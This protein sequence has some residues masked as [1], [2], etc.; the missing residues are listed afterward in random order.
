[1]TE[2]SADRGGRKK[3]YYRHLV[4]R[5]ML[6]NILQKTGQASITKSYITQ[7]TNSA[8]TEKPY[9]SNIRLQSNLIILSQAHLFILLLNPDPQI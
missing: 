5:Q 3:R 2:R 7:H 4:S 9:S 1:M 6:L 8:K